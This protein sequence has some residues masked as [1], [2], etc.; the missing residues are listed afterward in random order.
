M[1]M[2][3]YI[4]GRSDDTMNI[5]GKRIGPAEIE[6][7]VVAG[8][9]AREAAAIAIPHPVKGSAIVV[10]AVLRPGV[11]DTDDCRAAMR[12]EVVVRLGKAF[13]PEYVICVPAL[14]R[15]RNAKIMR[16]VIRAAWTGEDPGEA[17]ALENPEAVDTI[18]QLAER[19]MRRG[20]ISVPVAGMLAERARREENG[21]S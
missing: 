17:S 2:A 8:G 15:T 5:A 16:R 4:R 7:A 9:S 12:E 1:P 20:E 13:R 11:D 18:R 3:W 19:A 10:V 6:S 21:A 14:P